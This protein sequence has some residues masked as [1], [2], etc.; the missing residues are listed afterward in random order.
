[1]RI[2]QEEAPVDYGSY[3]FP[4][5]QWAELD[6]GESPEEAY[7]SGFLPASH[8][9]EDPRV[10]FYRA[11]SLRFDLAALAFDKKRR[12]LQRRGEKAGLRWTR[13]PLDAFCAAPP[14]AWKERVLEW[15]RR[16]HDPPFMTAGR[17]EHLLQKP[18]L[19]EVAVISA[20][21]R[22]VGLVLLPRTAKSAHY[23]FSLYDPDWE[24]S[25]SLGKWILGE[26]AAK[27]RAEGLHHLYLGT[28]YGDK[29]RYKFQGASAG[30]AFF[31]G[32]G[33]STNLDELDRRLT[34]D[35]RG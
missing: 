18:F 25:L 15:V 16:R 22:W 5:V 21:D 17:L 4:Y 7:A 14:E 34:A 35:D 6:A 30:V 32:N 27:L 31:D 2:F 11:R 28:A 9:F 33:W 20:G 13:H 26:T 10:L 12:Y 23:W 29:A 3:R 24:P 1:M 8:R 19:N